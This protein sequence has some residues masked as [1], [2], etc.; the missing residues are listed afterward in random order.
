[1]YRI[2]RKKWE[3]CV[4]KLVR[5]RQGNLKRKFV[6][7]IFSVNQEVQENK[8]EKKTKL[9]LEKTIYMLYHRNIKII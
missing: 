9:F 7:L 6:N 8:Q 1:M 3:L 4:Y 5:Y 2:F